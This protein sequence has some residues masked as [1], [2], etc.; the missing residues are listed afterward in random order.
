MNTVQISDEYDEF[1]DELIWNN[2]KNTILIKNKDENVV[3]KLESYTKEKYNELAQYIHV[4]DFLRF[5]F[6]LLK[7]VKNS[8]NV[9]QLGEYDEFELDDVAN[10]FT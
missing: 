10:R 2:S 4:S 9:T 3:L 8:S 7:A 5:K 6:E 1:T